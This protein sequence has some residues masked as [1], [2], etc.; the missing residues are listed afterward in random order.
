MNHPSSHKLI[1]RYIPGHI[2]HVGCIYLSL[3]AIFLHHWSRPDWLQ[4]Y[5]LWNLFSGQLQFNIHA[6]IG[7]FDCIE[8]GPKNETHLEW[9]LENNSM[10]QTKVQHRWC[11]ENQNRWPDENSSTLQYSIS[12]SWAFP[13][14]FNGRYEC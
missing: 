11:I 13:N 6:F 1:E 7:I 8:P 10:Y 12:C 14:W 4:S 5:K 2:H 3:C 9:T